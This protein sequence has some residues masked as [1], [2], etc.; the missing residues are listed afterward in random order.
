M[1]AYSLPFMAKQL[2]KLYPSHQDYVDKV[3]A[4]AFV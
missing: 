4:A 2:L 1:L 3:K